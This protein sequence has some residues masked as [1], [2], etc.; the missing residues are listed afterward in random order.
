MFAQN[1]YDPNLINQNMYYG[2]YPQ[3]YPPQMPPMIM[4]GYGNYGFMNN[5]MNPPSQFGPYNPYNNYQQPQA[6]TPMYSSVGGGYTVCPISRY[7]Q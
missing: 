1:Y 2:G 5:L 3:G 4:G 7:D 6:P